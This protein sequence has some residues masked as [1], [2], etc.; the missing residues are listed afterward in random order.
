[1]SGLSFGLEMFVHPLFPGGCPIAYPQADGGQMLVSSLLDASF[2]QAA[3]SGS[4]A[5]SREADDG[6][7]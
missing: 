4:P 3:G 1:M 6:D 2:S 5:G 7:G